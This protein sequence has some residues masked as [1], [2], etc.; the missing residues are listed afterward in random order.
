MP[1]RNVEECRLASVK[2]EKT[3]SDCVWKHLACQRNVEECRLGDR[4]R[5]LYMAGMF[6]AAHKAGALK[7]YAR[8]VCSPLQSTSSVGS[9]ETD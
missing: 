1:E 9:G 8:Y 7:G 4:E 2:K 3:K 6:A 5:L